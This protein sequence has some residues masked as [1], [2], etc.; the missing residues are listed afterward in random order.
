MH[1]AE[2]LGFLDGLLRPRAGVDVVGRPVLRQ[3]GHRD[4]EELARRP[5]LQ[6]EDLVVVRDI[7]DLAA[8][9]DGLLVHAVEDLAPVAVFHDADAAAVDVPDVLL[10]LLDDGLGKHRGARGEVEDTIAH[11]F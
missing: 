11:E 4:H 8:V 10:R 1:L 5:A 3:E 7:R 6:E 9:R 2:A